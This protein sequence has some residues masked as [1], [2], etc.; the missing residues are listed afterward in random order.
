MLGCLPAFPIFENIILQMNTIIEQ[1]LQDIL[2]T[3]YV[4]WDRFRGKTVLVTGANG[5]LPAYLVYT[6]LYLN[7][8][9][10]TNTRVLALVRNI[11]KAKVRFHN[12]LDDEY[13]E[14]I[15]QDV[16]TPIKFGNGKIDYIIHAASQASP[17]YYG[18]DPVGT[19]NAN[20]L[21]TINTLDLAHRHQVESYLYFS[22]GSVYGDVN[23]EKFPFTEEDYGYID[24]LKGQSCYGE[25]KRMGEQYCVAYHTQ[26]GV[27]AKMVRIFHTFGPGLQFD[28]CRVFAD[29]I[30]DIVNNED[31]VLHSDGAAVRLFCYITDAVKAYFKILLDGQMAEA[32]NVANPAGE[33]SI[34][35]LAHLLV[36]MYPEKHLHFKVEILKGD[37]ITDKMKSPIQRAIPSIAKMQALGWN[38][39]VS[40]T[41]AFRRTIDS[42]REN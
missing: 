23:P 5:M 3:A 17:K 26:Y 12:W 10:Q 30:K 40:V 36:D 34:R 4:D 39:T 6:L 31:I 14:L 16:C 25:S 35:D 22:T 27:P 41:E 19:I 24:L 11:D 7:R 13:L 21:G 29:F 9:Q 38:P 32:Y 42:F 1:D 37:L 20:V 28:D 8:T 15:V 2:S 33:I 18:V